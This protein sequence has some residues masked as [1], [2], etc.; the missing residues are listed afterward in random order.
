MVGAF[1][2]VVGNRSLKGWHTLTHSSEYRSK[3]FLHFKP[4]TFVGGVL[5]FGKS[6]KNF[7]LPLEVNN[8]KRAL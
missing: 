5:I 8:N 7:E 4:V 6:N 3:M 1:F 2:T